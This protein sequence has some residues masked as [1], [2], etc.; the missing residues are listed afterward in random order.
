MSQYFLGQ[1]MMGGYSF[2]PKS[3]AYCDGRLLPL[4]Q[5]QALFSLIGVQY[6]G[7]GST[8]FALPDLRSRVPVA[9]G[10]SIDAGWQPPP[11][12]IGE[13]AGAESV[14]L[15]VAQ[16]PSHTHV[17]QASSNTGV[18]KNPAGGVIGNIV[19][20]LYGDGT[21]N[22]VMLNAQTCGTAG[23]SQPHPN[24]Q[25]Y[26]VINFCIALQGIFPSRN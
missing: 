5:N 20:P 21:T 18:A 19:T 2:A 14:T 24:V 12:Q 23:G 17:L 7:N 8:T 1:I 22:P 3:F 4:M 9:Y 10:T 6:G 25:P 16:L 15:T 11:M 13:S 26:A